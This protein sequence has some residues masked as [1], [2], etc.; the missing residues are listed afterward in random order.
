MAK[1]KQFENFDSCYDQEYI[2][3]IK[4]SVFKIWHTIDTPY[5]NI[6]KIAQNYYDRETQGGRKPE[7][8]YTL[9]LRPS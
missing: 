9:D 2:V 7:L 4:N 3:K 8:I 1:K 6:E 5:E